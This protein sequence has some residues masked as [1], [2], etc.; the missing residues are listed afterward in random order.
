MKKKWI[1]AAVIIA[2]IILVIKTLYVAGSFKTITPHIEGSISKIYYG[3]PGAE[4]M[5]LDDA[6]GSIFISSADRWKTQMGLEAETDGI[7]LLQPDS[8]Q[9]PRKLVTTYTRAFHPHGIS[10]LRVN[11]VSYLFVVN[12]NAVGSSVEIFEYKSD[13]LFHLSSIKGDAMCCPNDVVA[14]TPSTFYVTNDHGNKR[15]FKRWMEEYLQVP[16][17]S[18]LYYNGTAIKTAHDGL[19]YA[20]GINVSNNGDRL[21]VAT[22]TGRSLL[23]FD[24]DAM[25]GKLS[26]AGELNLKTGLDNIDVDT[27]GNLWLAAHPKLLAFVGH[28]K[29][30]TKLSPSQVIKLTPGAGA[31]YA[32][33]EIMMDDGSQLSASSIALRYKNQLYV[34]GVF[35]PRILRM[36]TG[37]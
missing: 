36:D 4:D 28:A 32:I 13:T 15:G 16:Q 2:L 23:T 3:I 14:I 21:Y 19:L 18:V 22:T 26:L 35:Q 30:S 29:D 17:S 5:D 24:R 9:P 20:N 25:T 33:E 7:Y 6:K 10:F 37:K 27:D 12:H 11:A 1:L 31:A 34:G 8:A